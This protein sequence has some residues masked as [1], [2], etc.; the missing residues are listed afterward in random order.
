MARPK[1]IFEEEK[2]KVEMKPEPKNNTSPPKQPEMRTAVI[3]PKA[4]DMVQVHILRG[5]Y[6]RYQ[7]SGQVGQI[8]AFPKEIAEK[9]IANGDGVKV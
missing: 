4:T 1:R 5:L 3:E 8:K 9:I 6:H 2:P 7:L